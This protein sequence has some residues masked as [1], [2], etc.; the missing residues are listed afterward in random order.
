MAHWDVHL[1]KRL[2]SKT[3]KLR[4]TVLLIILDDKYDEKQRPGFSSWPN[5]LVLSIFS[6]IRGFSYHENFP[7]I[8]RSF[9]AH[10]VSRVALSMK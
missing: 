9:I 3:Y 1:L 7:L 4:S 8:K 2:G 5:N 6:S 10:F